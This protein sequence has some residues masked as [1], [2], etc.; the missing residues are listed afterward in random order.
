MKISSRW[1]KKAKTQEQKK[2]VMLK[3]T[4]AIPALEMLADMIKDD[5]ENKRKKTVSKDRYQEPSWA[6]YQADS[7]GEERALRSILKLLSIKNDE[8]T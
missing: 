6:Y 1:I 4:S 7:V 2:E 5:I 3:I 8:E